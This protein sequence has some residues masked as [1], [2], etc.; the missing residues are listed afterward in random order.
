[1]GGPLG[2]PRMRRLSDSGVKDRDD[3]KSLWINHYDLV[4]DEDELISAP[5]RI[6]RD[7]VRRERMEGDIARNA[8]ADR[9]REVHVVQPEQ[10]AAFLITRGDPGAL[11]VDK[12][13]A[14]AGLSNGG[15]DLRWLLP[16]VPHS[17]CHCGPHGPR[18]SCYRAASRIFGFHVFARRALWPS[19]C[20]N[21]FAALRLHVLVGILALSFSE[22]MLFDFRPRVVLFLSVLGLGRARRIF[23]SEDCVAFMPPKRSEG[24]AVGRGGGVAAFG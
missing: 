19:C 4:A 2:P 7:D 13:R 17:R 24:V 6:N 8:C 5:I 10:R 1:M 3:L 14:G 16:S 12:L 22:L 23:S 21:D 9:D 18:R 15:W 20:R 11:L